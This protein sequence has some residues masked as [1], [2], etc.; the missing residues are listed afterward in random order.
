MTAI[1][2]L[3]MCLLYFICVG[4]DIVMFFLQI[5]LVLLWRN[6]D[7]LVPFDNAGKSLVSTVTLKIPQ[8]IKTQNRLSEKGKLI[9]ALVAFA[10]A[11]II[12]GSI[13]RLT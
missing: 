1:I 5:R 13:L 6:I 2:Y 9:I 4:I 8:F 12:L 7:W 11:R 10:I 3:L